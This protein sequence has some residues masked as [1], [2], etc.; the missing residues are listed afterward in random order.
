MVYP[1]YIKE[2]EVYI[3]KKMILILA[4]LWLGLN[5]FAN[6]VKADDYNKA[7]IGHVISETLKN[8]EIDHKS[9]LESEMSRLGHLYALEMV[10]ILEKHLPYILDSV[11]TELR[12]KAD[13]EY[14]C[15]L[16]EDTKALDKDCI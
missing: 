5:A 1:K 15:K 6:S 8:S 9:I 11:M 2:K 16:L 14:K 12:L 7:V 13:H 4:V 3:M 10:S